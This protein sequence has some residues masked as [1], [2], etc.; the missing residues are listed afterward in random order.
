[1]SWPT[2]TTTPVVRLTFPEDHSTPHTPFDPFLEGVLETKDPN[3]TL[4]TQR[5][6][7]GEVGWIFG[8]EQLVFA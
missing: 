7:D 1:M 3:R 5:L 4:G 2:A 8:E 6:R